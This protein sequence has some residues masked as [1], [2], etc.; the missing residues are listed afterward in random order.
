MKRNEFINW[1]EDYSENWTITEEE[2][3]FITIEY[4]TMNGESAE[5][6]LTDGD[7]QEYENLLYDIYMDFNVDD[8]VE[9]WIGGL[10]GNSIREMVEEA[11]EVE[12]ELMSLWQAVVKAGQEQVA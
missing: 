11:E 12:Y 9:E 10:S 4:T 8:C 6:T 5:F 2:D 3:R 1:L 7:E